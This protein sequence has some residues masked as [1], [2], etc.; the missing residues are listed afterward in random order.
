MNTVQLNIRYLN[1]AILILGQLYT[2]G[3][4]QIE[5]G[6]VIYELDRNGSIKIVAVRVK[7]KSEVIWKEIK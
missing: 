1:L 2:K 3:Y 4:C 5:D 7:D 6:A